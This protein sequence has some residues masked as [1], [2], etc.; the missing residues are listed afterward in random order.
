MKP[1]CDQCKK[2]TTGFNKI[3]YEIGGITLCGSC[4]DKLKAFKSTKTY[5]TVEEAQ[6]DFDAVMNDASDFDEEIKVAI[7]AHY[8][9]IIDKLNIMG[10]KFPVTTGYNFEG[11][12]ITE[13]LDIVVGEV[14]IGTGMFSTFIAGFEDTFGGEVRAYTSKLQEFRD[15]AKYRAIECAVELNANALIGCKYDF[16]NFTNDKIGVV[17]SGTAVIYE[18]KNV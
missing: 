8:Q 4:K 1:K 15:I 6:S 5:K 3:G 2:S 10:I 9:T 14:V 11:Y 7:T 16:V 18:K 13:Y 17:F 12:N